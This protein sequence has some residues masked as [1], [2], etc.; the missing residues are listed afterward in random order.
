LRVL[1]AEVGWRNLTQLDASG[2]LLES[3]RA[4]QHCSRLRRLL[5]ARNHLRKIEGLGG[6][7]QLEELDVAYNLLGPTPGASLHMVGGCTRLRMI[8][9][10]GNPFAESVF[11]VSRPRPH[12]Q[13][14]SD[15]IPSL[16]LID[17]QPLEEERPSGEVE[18]GSKDTA[19]SNNNNKNNNSNN[20][21]NNDNRCR[22]RDDKEVLQRQSQRPRLGAMMTRSAGSLHSRREE[23][24]GRPWELLRQAEGPRVL[25][26]HHPTESWTRAVAAPTRNNQNNNNNNN[27]NNDNNTNNKNKNRQDRLTR[28]ASAS[29][30]HLLTSPAAARSA[31][32]GHLLHTQQPRRFHLLRQ[33]LLQPRPEATSQQQLQQQQKQQ[34]QQ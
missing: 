10:A 8:C 22:D 28:S 26:Y 21:S 9:V 1:P 34:Q 4:L 2:N 25:T 5:L 19:H 15:L 33:Q 31:S 30:G 6:M 13:Q 14:L 11:A 24:A 29:A 23:I 32:A 12:R 27:N 20:N 18:E 7:H 17:G 16:E 3:T